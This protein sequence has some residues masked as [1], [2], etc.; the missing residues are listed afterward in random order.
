MEIL[1]YF[2]GL[3][4]TL[5]TSILLFYIQRKQ[6]KKDKK[7][8]IREAERAEESRISLELEM[9]TAKLA[10]ATAMALKRGKVNGEVEEGIEAYNKA[11]AAFVEFERKQIVKIREE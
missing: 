1:S 10:Y 8:S 9:A 3:L 5:I 6:G 11:R 7:Y 4:P 2:I